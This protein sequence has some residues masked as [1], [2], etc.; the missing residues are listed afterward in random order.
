MESPENTARPSRI[1]IPKGQNPLHLPSAF[2]RLIFG[3]EKTVGETETV[4]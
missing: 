1:Q 4:N 2:F 3:L